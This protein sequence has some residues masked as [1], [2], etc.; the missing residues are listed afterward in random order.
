MN[1]RASET[2]LYFHG[3][4]SSPHSQ[5][6]TRLRELL[7]D[8]VL[9]APDLNVP[10]FEKLDY[11]AMID[12]GVARGREVRPAVIAGSSLGSLVALEVARCGIEA[13]LVLIAPPLGL[14]SQ[15]IT[16]L[17]AGDP[18]SMFNHA[19]GENAPIHRAFFERLARVD[20][21]REPPAQPVTAIIGRHDETVPFDEV[22]KKWR[23]W[24]ESGKLAEGS[25]FIEIPEGDHG[26][27]EF[28]GQ[29]ADEIRRAVTT[30]PSAAR[31]RAGSP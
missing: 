23:E 24:E 4:A 17:P 28:A 5:K 3:F 8:F 20:V 11:D 21:D 27:V 12:L 18:L 19:R 1:G 22:Q 29:I 30:R 13:P 26:L 15:W 2:I 31:S 9:V 25:R 14:A 6:V 10:S 7:D 16:V